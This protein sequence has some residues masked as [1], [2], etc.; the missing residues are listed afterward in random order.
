VKKILISALMTATL[1]AGCEDAERAAFYILQPDDYPHLESGDTRYAFAE[2]TGMVVCNAAL[3]PERVREHF[4][5]ALVLAAFS[6]HS[7]P[8]WGANNAFW[9]EF[10]LELESVP[11]FPVG[12]WP[13]TLELRLSR[14]GGMYLADAILDVVDFGKGG[15]DGLYLDECWAFLPPRIRDLTGQ[16]QR[17]WEAHAEGF[18]A[19]WEMR[20]GPP[21]L[22]NVGSMKNG[23][24][25]PGVSLARSVRGSGARQA[26]PQRAARIDDCGEPVHGA[27]RRMVRGVGLGTA[28]GEGPLR[29]PPESHEHPRANTRSHRRIAGS[30]GTE[31]PPVPLGA[32]AP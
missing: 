14:S 17:D 22:G 32:A 15:Y 28:Q 2:Q 3:D 13:N 5:H 12:D 6:S 1:C 16:T 19:Q 24:A 8:I 4:P 9:N 7:K 31:R 25:D 21:I 30:M 11:V 10:R 18:F 26:A 20:K 29:H 23:G 27:R